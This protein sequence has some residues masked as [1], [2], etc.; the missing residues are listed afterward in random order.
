VWFA[1]LEFDNMV[2]FKEGG[3]DHDW[4]D[5]EDGED[6]EDKLDF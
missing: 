6:D 3:A 1:S 4:E 5:D 2:F